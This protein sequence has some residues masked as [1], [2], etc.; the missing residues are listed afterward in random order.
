[1]LSRNWIIFFLVLCALGLTVRGGAEPTA[2]DD[3]LDNILSRVSAVLEGVDTVTPSIEPAES[4]E[5]KEITVDDAVTLALT[6]NP[7]VEIT[8]ENVKAA[9]A[10]SKAAKSGYKPTLKSQAVYSYSPDVEVDIGGAFGKIF[11]SFGSFA[12]DKGTL[13]GQLSLEQV[14]YAGGQIRALVRA[15]EYLARSEE[16]KRKTTLAQLELDTR[17]A[18]YD[19]LLTRALVVV[20]QDSVKTFERHLADVKQMFDVGMVS[21]FEV[22]RA[23]TELSARQA[24]LESARAAAR[25]ALLNLKRILNVPKDV[26][27]RP[28]GTLEW[29]PVE[30]TVEDL[31][32]KAMQNR[33]ELQALDAGIA[34]ANQQVVAKKGSYKPKAAASA[35]YSKIEGGG[36][37]AVD[38]WRFTL[39]AE[40]EIYSGGR[41]KQEVLE[42]E[43]QVRS[44]QKQR[45]EVERLIELDVL[46]SYTRVQESVAKIRKEKKTV[47]LGAEGLR[48]AELRFTQGVGTQAETLDADLAFTQAK[49]TLVKALRDYAVAL[50]S[51]DKAVGQSRA[52]TEPMP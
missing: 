16:W 11:S 47:E 44:L 22:L 18:Y 36:S 7:Q 5:M 37:F 32:A 28:L 27:L 2:G 31:L 6:Q 43:A 3:T 45:E 10:R 40:W 29:R 41:R 24:D 39:G 42:A 9:E 20:A 51:L 19:V 21:R 30:V 15:S 4:G 49:T 14:V 33:P 38:G 8:N 35:Q 1:M 25:V 46:Q 48:L 50:A 17:T 52:L 12:P 13:T 26:N 34:A 23:E